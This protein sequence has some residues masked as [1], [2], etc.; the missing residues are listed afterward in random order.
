MM[1][2]GTSWRWD[3]ASRCA[4]G[5]S[6]IACDACRQFQCYVCGGWCADGE[7]GEGLARNVCRFCASFLPRQGC[8]A[9]AEDGV[10]PGTSRPCAACGETGRVPYGTER[11]PE[12]ISPY[13]EARRELLIATGQLRP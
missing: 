9:C 11:D 1:E 7:R 8:A 13:T 2:L 5:Q 3:P 10:E 12:E 4:C 6:Y